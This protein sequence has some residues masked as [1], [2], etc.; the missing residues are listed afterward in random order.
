MWK[1]WLPAIMMLLA[2]FLVVGCETKK[3]YT[4]ATDSPT[5]GTV[6][7]SVDE[8]FKPVVDELIKVYE[9]S[10][11]GTKIIAHYKP[12]AECIKDLFRDS[13]IGRASC[14]ERVCLAV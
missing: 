11:E 7:I 12:E 9:G 1:N 4:S 13:E 2:L 3:T 8:S 6:N 5:T 10:Y 14:R